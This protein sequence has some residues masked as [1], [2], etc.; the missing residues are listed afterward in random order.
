MH[1]TKSKGGQKKEIHLLIFAKL[2]PEWQAH[3]TKFYPLLLVLGKIKYNKKKIDRQ[4]YCFQIERQNLG[5]SPIFF[6]STS[7]GHYVTLR[8]VNCQIVLKQP[9][10]APD[11]II[12][13]SYSPGCTG[14]LTG[15]KIFIFHMKSYF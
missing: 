11:G 6:H 14:W 8:S 7:S 13:K 1:T 5:G 4:K 3:L 9:S 12:Q 15:I 10:G 2:L